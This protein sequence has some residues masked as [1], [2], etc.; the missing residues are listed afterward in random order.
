MTLQILNDILNLGQIVLF[1]WTYEICLRAFLCVKYINSNFDVLLVQPQM[2]I[3]KFLSSTSIPL[4]EFYHNTWTYNARASREAKVA[5]PSPDIDSKIRFQLVT[6]TEQGAF[7]K[8][9]QIDKLCK[10][11]RV[12]LAVH[13]AIT[14]MTL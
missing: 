13:N 7:T 14:P 6:C 1:L 8:L 3:N 4:I 2:F 12:C 10:F 9:I 11:N 5:P